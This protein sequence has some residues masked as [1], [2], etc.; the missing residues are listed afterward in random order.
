MIGG[1][2]SIELHVV[3]KLLGVDD[4]VTLYD[5]MRLHQGHV[6]RLGRHLFE[7]YRVTIGLVL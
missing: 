2:G 7:F 3:D 5:I 6:R 4:A 1:S